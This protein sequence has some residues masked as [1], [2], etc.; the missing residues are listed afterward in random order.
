MRY[1]NGD[2]EAL[3]ILIN[4]N[5]RLV[6]N[7]ASRYKSKC[8]NTSLDFMDLIPEGNI[9]LQLA[10]EKYDIN[11]TCKLST[12]AYYWIRLYIGMSLIN[13]RNVKLPVYKANY[14]DAMERYKY[15]FMSKYGREPQV[16]DYENGLNIPRNL[17][18]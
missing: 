1:K 5:L 6:V 3:N 2:K 10:I 11:K 18:E 17:I 4:S 8:F 12:Y 7:V 13:S 9:G 15:E 14:L 16:C